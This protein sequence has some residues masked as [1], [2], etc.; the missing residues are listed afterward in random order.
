MALPEKL[1]M[2]VN[3][4]ALRADPDVIKDHLDSSF[5]ILAE[6]K[7]AQLVDIATLKA[8]DRALRGVEG[9]GETFDTLKEI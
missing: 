3:I 1:N 8:Y 4:D 6:A 2:K 7:D 9:L 5:A